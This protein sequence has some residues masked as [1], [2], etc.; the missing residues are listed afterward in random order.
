MTLLSFLIK[1]KLVAE[2][3]EQTCCLLRA[4]N[5]TLD[6]AAIKTR[7]QPSPMPFDPPVTMT[8]LSTYR[9]ARPTG[10]D[11]AGAVVVV[12][13]SDIVEI[14][15]LGYVLSCLFQNLSA[16]RSISKYLLLI[17]TWRWCEKSNAMLAECLSAP[18][19]AL[20][21]GSCSFVGKV[22]M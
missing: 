1:I 5:T 11:G 16:F 22:C 18:C 7:T 13:A 15:V 3:P 12:A 6:P 2:V 17:L 14:L 9:P 21:Y 10:A 8:T 4:Q 20:V 19:A